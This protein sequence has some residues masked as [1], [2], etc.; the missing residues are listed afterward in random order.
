L[1][2]NKENI[3]EC[4]EWGVVGGEYRGWL[5]ILL[6]MGVVDHQFSQKANNQIPS[7]F[8]RW[9]AAAIVFNNEGKKANDANIPEEQ[10]RVA[11]I[12]LAWVQVKL[13]EVDS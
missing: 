10:A 9:I 5:L 1:N 2:P 4:L 7:S 3:P 13:D 12:V 6:I 8:I 11:V